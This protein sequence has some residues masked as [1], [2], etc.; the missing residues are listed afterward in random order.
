M[1]PLASSAAVTQLPDA[2]LA[3]VPL[4]PVLP[5][6]LAVSFAVDSSIG[7]V[8]AVP[9]AVDFVAAINRIG[10]AC[11]VI[12]SPFAV[13]FAPTRSHRRPVSPSRRAPRAARTAPEW[14]AA[15]R[16]G[17]RRPS[18]LSVVVRRRTLPAHGDSDAPYCEW[19]A[20]ATVRPEFRHGGAGSDPV[21]LPRVG[22]GGHG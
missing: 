15:G 5:L 17:M 2:P 22:R 13:G 8:L 18:G 6:A 16:W 9:A 11:H 12:A 10:G 7:I 21:A 4:A 19:S 1:R 14:S 20:G 3:S